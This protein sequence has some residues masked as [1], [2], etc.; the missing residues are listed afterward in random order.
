MVSKTISRNFYRTLLNPLLM[1]LLF[2][3][4]NKESV[5]NNTTSTK[6]LAFGDTTFLSNGLEGKIYFLEPGTSAIPLFDTMQ[7][8]KTIYADSINVPLQSW[9]S[10]F[11][12]L[13]GRF[14]W[15]GIEYNG[16]FTVNK[17]GHYM[18]RLVSD[19]GS[20]LF[21]DDSLII[22]NDGGHGAIS[23][24]GELYLKGSTHKVKIQ[25]YQGPRYEIALQLFF[26]LN[27]EEEQIFPG[28][29]FILSPG[30]INFLY[31]NKIYIAAGSALLLLF[32][33]FIYSRK[34]KKRK[35][36]KN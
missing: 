9:S 13:P 6:S 22:D 32:L 7:T 30:K 2:I 18:F 16:Y 27:N 21:I 11:P 33:F 29:Y 1:T 14:E 19:D 20:K 25:Y 31:T 24:T 34:K 15:F 12:G 26:K 36:A 3:G 8:V 28:K 35:E 23:K 10:G 4:C 17:L 5:H